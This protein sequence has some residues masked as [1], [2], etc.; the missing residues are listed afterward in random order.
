MQLIQDYFPVFEVNQVL[1]SGHLNDAF[2]YLDEQERLTRANLTGIGIVCGLEIGF[3]KVNGVIQLSKGCGITSQGYLIV[4]PET[5]NL[6]SYQDYVL[7]AELDYPSFKDASTKAQYPL[8]ELFA[9][10]PK[11]TPLKNPVPANFLDDKAVLL[12]LELKKQGLRNCSPNNCDDKGSVVIATVRRL[13]VRKDDLKKIG[14]T[15]LMEFQKSKMLIQEVPLRRIRFA[16][17]EDLH[18]YQNIYK[19]YFSHT[20][21]GKN[22]LDRLSDAVSQAYD[23]LKLLIPDLVAFQ[24]TT[25]VSIFTFAAGADVKGIQYYFDLL[26]D[27]TSAYH[28]LRAALLEQLAICLPG[29]APFPQ[30]LAL[31]GLAGNDAQDWRTGYFP[32]PAVTDP[33]RRLGELRFL[34]DR[35]N[36]L[37]LNFEI[38]VD[39]QPSIVPIKITPSQAGFRHISGRSMPFYYKTAMRPLWDA[40]RKGGQSTG[41]LS[42]RVAAG[43][44]DHASN[45]LNYDLEPYGFFRIEGHVRKNIL[46]V[47]IGKMIRD[48]GLPISIVYL[49][50][51]AVGGFLEK[52]FA[53][54]HVAGVTR[55]GTF[56]VVYGGTGANANLML[57]DFALPYRIEETCC[58]CLC[59]VAV[60]ECE[61]EWFDSKQYLGKLARMD[62]PVAVS[63]EHDKDLLAQY[64]VIVIYRYEIQ[65]S[66]L[67][68]GGPVQVRIPIAE[69][70]N[71]ELSVIAR[72]LNEKFPTGLVFDH[73]VAT[74]K[75]V[76]R[77][78]ADQTFCI[79][80]G[81]LQGNQIRYQYKPEGISR[82]QK[83]AWESLGNIPEY[84]VVCHLRDEYRAGEYRWMQEDEYYSPKYPTPAPMPTALEL[85][86]WEDMIRVRAALKVLPISSVLAQI[87]HQIDENYNVGS[88]EVEALLIGSWAN[89]SWKSR[90]AS[91]NAATEKQFPGFFV[92]RQKVTGKTG[93]SDIDLLISCSGAITVEQVLSMLLEVPEIKNC[94]YNINMFT[95]KKDAQKW[96]QLI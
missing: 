62:Y 48:S 14:D 78:F 67:V 8:W 88:P 65:G 90:N 55:G 3:D 84:K 76:I 71:G 34:F 82:W 50:A 19:T 17:P 53:I 15:T 25:L 45:P 29:S 2:N 12:F 92:L 4:E 42:W 41:I 58:D 38:P 30:H 47:D 35:L 37:L 80:W 60:K 81:G 36:Q 56:V 51:E 66:S 61:F 64:Y 77:Y 95:G 54:E 10:N 1:T 32:S 27:L 7:P 68:N 73:D 20:E 21:G 72:Y 52:N 6:T 93:P 49:N 33:Q 83:K 13:L 16:T 63:K 85:M 89:G 69:L 40:T 9:D 22:V 44:P 74:H 75:L 5:V 87:R 31:G 86:A 23:L 26:R 94:G 79:E 70:A 24:K 39:P 46:N 28:E 59:R 96:R 18:N 57:C 43:S 91:D 11:A